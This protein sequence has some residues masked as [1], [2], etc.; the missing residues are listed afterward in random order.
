[1]LPR[2]TKR[3][4]KEAQ[5]IQVNFKD[6]FDLEI[7]GDTGLL[8]RVKFTGAEG[9]V[10]S[11][12]KFTLQFKFDQNY[13]IEAPEVIFVGAHIPEHPHIYSNGY[14]CLSTL[15]DD[16]T[17][18]LKVSA[19]VLSILSMLSSCPAKGRPVNDKSFTSF[20]NGR[21]PKSFSWD[22]EDETC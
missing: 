19:V 1:M 11:G 7:D 18:S 21:S 9:T 2:A 17:P 15:Y 20:A 5:D 16:W 8:W 3:L 4:E 13:P 10:F 6:A 12:E 14:I 22:F